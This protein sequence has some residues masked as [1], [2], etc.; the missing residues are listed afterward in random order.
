MIAVGEAHIPLFGAA[1]DV[2]ALIQFGAQS[3]SC[4]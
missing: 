3:A 4:V 1:V 2:V